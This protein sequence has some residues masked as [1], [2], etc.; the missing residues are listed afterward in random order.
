MSP[1]QQAQVGIIIVYLASK[2]EHLMKVVVMVG[3]K[4][5]GLGVSHSP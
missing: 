3:V 4:L 2:Q 5:R 1:K